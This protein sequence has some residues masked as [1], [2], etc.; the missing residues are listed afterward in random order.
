M[1]Q[2]KNPRITMV[3]KRTQY[4]EIVID[5][6]QGYS[7]PKTLT[8]LFELCEDIKAN[9]SDEAVD[10]NWTDGEYEIESFNVSINGE[11]K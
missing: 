2:I 10:N 8:G 11:S 3:I 4:Q 7:M 1:T 9:P 6:Y 5:E